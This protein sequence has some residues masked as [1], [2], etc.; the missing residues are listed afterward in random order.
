MS[1]VFNTV[2]S[3][4]SFLSAFFQTVILIFVGFVFTRKDILE[5]SGKK[6]LSALIW[7]LASS[8]AFLR[9]LSSLRSSFSRFAASISALLLLFD[10]LESTADIS[11][12]SV[13]FAFDCLRLCT[14]ASALT[15]VFFCSFSHKGKIWWSIFVK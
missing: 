8:A 1:E 11:L 2:F 10:V 3:N 4:H 13:V 15:G 5:G 7:K 14:L 6:T 12:F 9:S